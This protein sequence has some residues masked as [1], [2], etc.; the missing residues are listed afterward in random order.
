MGGV[1]NRDGDRERE[2]ARRM[3]EE[4]GGGRGLGREMEIETQ[5]TAREKGICEVG[6]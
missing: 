6:D 3:H 5:R 2:G 4:G 1:G